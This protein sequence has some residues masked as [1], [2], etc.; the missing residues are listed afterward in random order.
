[1]ILGCTHY[2]FVQNY[3]SEVAGPKVKLVDPS[4]EVS[5][6]VKVF[7]KENNLLEDNIDR[8]IK[9]KFCITKKDDNFRLIIKKLLNIY[10]D[11]ICVVKL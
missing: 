1:L 11:D 3:I 5:N 6:R 10:V 7:L 9:R 4:Y 2:P 8:E